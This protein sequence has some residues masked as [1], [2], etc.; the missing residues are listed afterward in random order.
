MPAFCKP[1]VGRNGENLTKRQKN[2]LL[3]TLLNQIYLDRKRQLRKMKN[4]LLFTFL[5]TAWHGI[6][7][8][9]KNKALV[10][11]ISTY[12]ELSKESQLQYADDDAQAFYDLILSNALG[13]FS[14][15]NVTLLLNEKA[16]AAQVYNALD[17]LVEAT[18]END[19]II[20]YFSG[21]GDIETKTIRQRGFLLAHDS[22]RSG[23][24]VGGTIKVSDLQD[25]IET[26]VTSNKAKVILIT[27]ACRSGKLAG[28]TEGYSQTTA[29]LAEQWGN[30]VKILSSQPGELSDESSVWGNGHGIFTYS[31]IHGLVGMADKDKDGWVSLNELNIYLNSKVSAETNDAQHPVIVGHSTG[32]MSKV[33]QHKLELLEGQ[34]KV[35]KIDQFGVAS[36]RSNFSLDTISQQLYAKFMN[37]ISRKEIVRPE[38]NNGLK[39]YR[40]LAALNPNNKELIS[41]LNRALIAAVEESTQTL[42]NRY[43]KQDRT[44]LNS[45][46]SNAL[47]E[48]D[49][50]LNFISPTNRRYTQLKSNQLFLQSDLLQCICDPKEV[51]ESVAATSLRKLKSALK[52]TPGMPHLLNSIGNAFY[53]E[54]EY[55]SAENYYRAALLAAPTWIYPINNLGNLYFQRDTTRASVNQAIKMFEKSIDLQPEH[56]FAYT[57]L[58]IIYYYLHSLDHME[59]DYIDYAFSYANYAFSY[60][61]KVISLAPTIENYFWFAELHSYCVRDGHIGYSDE[62]EPHKLYEKALSLDS[63]SAE[64]LVGY[65]NYIVETHDKGFNDEALAHFKRAIKYHPTY[66]EA[67]LK[68]GNLIRSRSLY[69]QNNNFDSAIIYLN[70]GLKYCETKKDSSDFYNSIGQILIDKK[71]YKNSEKMARKAIMLEKNDYRNYYLLGVV[72]YESHN[73]DEAKQAFINAKSILGNQA[74]AELDIYLVRTLI[75]QNTMNDASIS[76][77]K[78]LIIENPE[79]ANIHLAASEFYLLK[80]DKKLASYYRALYYYVNSFN[81][82]NRALS[83]VWKELNSAAKFGYDIVND[84]WLNHEMEGESE[85]KKLLMKYS[86]VYTK[87]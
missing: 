3:T 68:I 27:D 21:H 52:L 79:N 16:T 26:F 86:K 42:L 15:E 13:E 9:S 59:Y 14:K 8:Q 35:Q 28:G 57:Q 58:A 69:Y 30:I 32:K 72:Y 80:K 18:H 11:G 1:H 47:E 66:K 39:Y 73:Y 84:E 61:R 20:I 12:K 10:I 40:K 60:A 23:Y 25:Y 17:H 51:T 36:P 48:V 46:Y 78:K 24:Q 77:L 34:L 85:F 38:S 82:K 22:P 45:D 70:R 87:K 63:T 49:S 6:Y 29:S 54:K 41:M 7:A 76:L 67:Y 37:A 75:K 62:E 4:V 81:L 56:P 33:D 2:E 65:G 83:Q 43:M 64:V 50:I 44:L 31:L 74:D 55:D 5:L 53:F 19:R 71:D